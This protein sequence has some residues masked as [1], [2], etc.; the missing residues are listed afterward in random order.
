MIKGESLNTFSFF[1]FL[2]KIYYNIYRKLKEG[3]KA[4]Q[5]LIQ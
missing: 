5:T 4:W 2:L 3:E 1:D